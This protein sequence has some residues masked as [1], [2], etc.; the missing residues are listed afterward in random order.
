MLGV[1][2]ILGRAFL[3]G[4][5]QAGKDD[6]VVL[7]EGLWK[8]RFA[9]DP[10]IAG[11]S[12]TLND[13]SYTVVGVMPS[14][15]FVPDVCIPINLAGEAQKVGKHG[16][17]VI[18]RLKPG[19]TLDQ[20]QTDLADVAHQLEQQYPNTNVGHRAQVVSLHEN[21]VGD[22]RRALLV[23]FVAVGFVL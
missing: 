20:A 3:P 14:V 11:K 18:G 19:V 7:N 17:Q 9:S 1:A 12:I 22:V 15:D 23:L 8:R 16:N 13:K 6:V 2:P 5:D 4:E 10:D 21:T